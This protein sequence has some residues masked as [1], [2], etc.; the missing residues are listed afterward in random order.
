MANEALLTVGIP[1][2]NEENFLAQTLE[3]IANQEFNDYVVY[4][5]DDCSSDRSLEIARK[6]A[7]KD[8]RIRIMESDQKNN[9]VKNWSRSLEVCNTK[10]FVW[11]GAHD[12]LHPRYFQDAVE[13]LEKN[14]KWAMVYP[15]STSIDSWNK[16]GETA[17]SDIE[18]VGMLQKEAIIKVASNLNHCTAIHGIFKTKILKKIPIKRIVG[19]D[20]LIIFL[21]SILGDIAKTEDVR[22]FRRVIREESYAEAEKRWKE[23]G[24]FESS[25]FNNFTI[26]TRECLINYKNLSSGSIFS[27]IGFMRSLANLFGSRFNI[28]NTEILKAVFKLKS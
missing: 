24:M 4:I 19:F 23:S 13:L 14:E 27:K 25:K 7:S 2:Y 15:M 21:T 16:Q 20:F 28:S 26:L 18:T 9:F 1:C 11:I 17:D 12:I 5:C 3:S 10:Y 6:Y 8:S 22:F